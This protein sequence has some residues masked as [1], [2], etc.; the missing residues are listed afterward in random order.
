MV[1][2]RA[3]I[4]PRI[5]ERRRWPLNIPNL[6]SA[7]R[8]GC[9]P[10]LLTL[11]W[12]GATGAFLVLFGLGLLSDVLDGVLARRFGQESE[13]GARLDQWADFALWVCFPLGAWWLWPEIVRREAPYVILAIV[14]LLLPTAI[15][16]TKYRAVPGY[17]TWSAKTSSVLMGISVPLLLIFD[18]AWPFRIAALFQLVCAVDELGITVLFAECRHDVPSVFHAARVRRGA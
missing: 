11:A 9:V 3:P 14:C 13:F 5:S 12:K 10:V 17:H 8:I 6:L 16:Y 2:G 1:P 7:F 15:A 4:V 18:V